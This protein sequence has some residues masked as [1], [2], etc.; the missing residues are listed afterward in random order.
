MSQ[1]Y[2]PSFQANTFHCIH[3]NV[4]AQQT[5]EDIM[6]KSGTP[7][8]IT[9]C[10]CTHCNQKSFWYKKEEKMIFPMSSIIEPPHNDMPEEILSEYIEAREVF[11]ISAKS[12]AALLRLSIQK[13]MPILG[14]K[15]ENINSDIASLTKKGL[16]QIV[17]QA[18]DVC[19]VIGNNAVHPGTIDLNDKPENV[20]TLFSIINFI[21]EEKISKPKLIENMYNLLPENNLK[22]I[23]KRDS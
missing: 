2:E 6:Q 12:S 15:G 23:N 4:Y 3:C 20:K 8:G 19:R 7:S 21:I 5:W 9:I 16:P 22:A 13:L 10:Q 11:S 17:Q 1:F 18:F 14:E